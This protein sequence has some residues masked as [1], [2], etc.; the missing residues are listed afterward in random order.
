MPNDPLSSLQRPIGTPKETPT[1]TVISG[2]P[3]ETSETSETSPPPET[4]SATLLSETQT[5]PPIELLFNVDP[6]QLQAEDYLAL[7]QHYRESRLVFEAAEAKPATVQKTR[8]PKSSAEATSK[9][10]NSL[11]TRMAAAKKAKSEDE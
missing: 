3:P 8:A 1:S 10:I 5:S 6:L 4:T 11:F 2:P 7:V 9:S